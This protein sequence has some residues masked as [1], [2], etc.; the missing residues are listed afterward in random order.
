MPNTP[1]PAGDIEK[2]TASTPSPAEPAT[3]KAVKPAETGPVFDSVRGEKARKAF[4]L[5]SLMSAD[6]GVLSH[7]LVLLALA[8]QSPAARM[9]LAEHGVPGTTGEKL[10]E[11]IFDINAD[12]LPEA[13]HEAAVSV[14]MSGADS[15]PET[16]KYVADR[17]GIDISSSWCFTETYLTGLNKNEIIKIGEEPGV[18][19]WVDPAAVTYRQDKYAGKALMALKKEDLIDIILNSGAALIGRVPA[20]VLGKRA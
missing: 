11:A 10:A 18:G 5:R 17:F 1:A 6:T 16:W 15:T 7:R 3:K 12:H 8:Q 2:P 13:L 20:E 4:V 14:I 19:I 9:H